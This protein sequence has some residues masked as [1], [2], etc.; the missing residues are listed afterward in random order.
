MLRKKIEGGICMDALDSA[1]KIEE[2]LCVK[3]TLANIPLG[4]TFELTPCCNMNCEMCF[5]RLSGQEMLE[6]GGLHSVEEWLSL[7][8]EMKDAGTLFVLITG[9]E[10]FLYPGFIDIYR[11]LKKLGFIITINTNGTLLTPEIAE[12]LAEDKPR[13]VNITLYGASNETYERLCHNPKGFDQ[14]MAAIKLLKEKKIDIKLNGSLVPEN[15]DEYQDLLD[16]AKSLD[17]YIKIDTYMF[18]SHRERKRTF[19]PKSRL[20]PIT[21]AN[22]RIAIKRYQSEEEFKEYRQEI[23]NLYAQGCQQTYESKENEVSCRA[24]RSAFWVT[25]QGHMTP[26]IFMHDPGIDVFEVGFAKAWQYIV[27][28]AKEI[29]MPKK[30]SSCE[31]QAFCP[32]CAAAGLTEQ[33]ATNKAPQYLCDYTDALIETLK[34]SEGEENENC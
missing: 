26:C 4:G 21:C 8:K 24:G 27:E 6:K 33:G 18:P 28:K 14:A 13:R 3:A 29:R 10:P 15:M 32:V 11:G 19:N 16:I 1:T 23:L 34:A 5:I 9:G 7:A 12:A 2:R 22:K 17:L 20:D 30:C 31:K 25:W